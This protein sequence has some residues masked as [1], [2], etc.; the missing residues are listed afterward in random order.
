MNRYCYSIRVLS[1]TQI[2][3]VSKL[4]NKKSH[5]LEIEFRI[6]TD[7]IIKFFSK[8]L[9]SLVLKHFKVNIRFLGVSYRTKL[10]FPLIY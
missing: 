2:R 10:H 5:L 7:K 8:N 3:M 9:Q 4:K 6:V 1:H